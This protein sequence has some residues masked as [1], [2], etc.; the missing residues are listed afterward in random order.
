MFDIKKYKRINIIGTSGSG[1]STISKK[2]ANILNYEY[3][4]MDNIFWGPNWSKEEHDIFINKLEKRLQKD[5]WVLDGNYKKTIPIKW[6]YTKLVIW[7][8][9][10]FLRTLF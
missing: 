4:E 5:S 1:K 8:D 10:S 3:I 9:Y 2:L 7:I 6:K